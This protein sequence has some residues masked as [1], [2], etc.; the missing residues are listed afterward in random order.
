MRDFPGCNGTQDAEPIKRNKLLCVQLSQT[1]AL[2]SECSALVSAALAEG[3]R[4]GKG[5]LTMA[6]GLSQNSIRAGQVITVQ[7]CTV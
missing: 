2:V 5:M 7:F 6:P 1:A 3:K 4:D